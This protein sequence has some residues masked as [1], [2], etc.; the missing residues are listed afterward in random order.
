MIDEARARVPDA[1]VRGLRRHRSRCCSRPTSC[2]R[3]CCSG[4][5]PIRMRAWRRGRV[6]AAGKRAAR[7]RGAGALPQ[8]RSVL[9]ALRGGRDAVVAETGATLWAAIRA[10]RRSARLRTRARPRRRAS[11]AGLHAPPAMFWRNAVQWRR[12][13]SPDADELDRRTSATLENAERDDDDRDVGAASGRVQEAPRRDAGLLQ[14]LG[15][16]AELAPRAVARCL[17]AGA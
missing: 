16:H 7:V 4:T 8:R 9:R 17:C 3:G 2:T 5:S 13:A 1:R 10:R 12:T 11:G 14:D 15:R 6:A